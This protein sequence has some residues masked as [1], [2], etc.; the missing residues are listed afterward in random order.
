MALTTG[1]LILVA[2]DATEYADLYARAQA[3]VTEEPA[4]YRL[5]SHKANTRTLVIDLTS[6]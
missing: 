5:I 2:V 4:K 3:H 6:A 1:K